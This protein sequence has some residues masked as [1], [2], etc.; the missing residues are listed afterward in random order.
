MGAFNSY[1]QL[2]GCETTDVRGRTVVSVINDLNLNILK[3]Q[4]YPSVLRYR[5]VYLPDH[6]IAPIGADNPLE[7][8]LLAK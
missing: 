1:S 3:W 5:I 8:C 4:S 2:W 7:R 6:S